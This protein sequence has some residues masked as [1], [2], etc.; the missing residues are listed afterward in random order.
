M[1]ARADSTRA[2]R[3]PKLQDVAARA[4]VSAGT[5]SNAL[6]H[7]EKVAPATL[8]RVVSAIEELGFTRNGAASTLAS[9]TS[10]VL[11]LVVI[12]L[13]NSLFVDITRGAQGPARAHGFDLQIADS[14]VD[15]DQQFSH[16]H[17]LQRARAAG[18]LLAPIQ[19]PHESIRFL[20]EH[21]VP[22]VLVN[23]APERD[24][25]CTVL[26]DN[27]QVGYLAARHLI[28]LGRTRIAFLGGLDPLQPVVQRRKGVLRA[29]GE[30]DGIQLLD[31]ET[32][33][34]NPPSGSAAGAAFVA[35]RSQ[36]RPDAVLAVTDLLAMAIISE[37]RAA[38]IR[39]PEDV[40]VMGCDHNSAAWGGAV[41][42]TSVNL[43]G[44][45]LGKVAVGL[46]LAEL[47]EAPEVHEHRTV[48]LEPSLIVRESTIGRERVVPATG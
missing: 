47:R 27:E 32:A 30:T 17:F 6:N 14:A 29:I 3:Q 18:V 19:E 4:G 31:I 24:D 26:I 36:D 20:R 16:L 21:S 37:F 48:V 34:L 38:G 35:M 23:Y 33:D 12:D 41:P 22:V 2:R 5:V 9:G 15:E 42:L 44:Q 46:M 10:T 28:R 1:R 8:H 7:P 13:M 25:C 45:E 43:R 11:G 39:V 40:A